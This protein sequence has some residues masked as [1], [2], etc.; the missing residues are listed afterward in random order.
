MAVCLTNLA[1]VDLRRGRVLSAQQRF[2]VAFP[3]QQELGDI[4]GQMVVL[5]GQATLC[6]QSHD[7]SAAR[8]LHSEV[9]RLARD[10]NLRQRLVPALVNLSGLEQQDR[11]F[12]EAEAHLSEAQ[13]VVD[14]MREELG[15]AEA[16]PL[17]QEYAAIIAS[18][19]VRLY[20]DS[21]RP[22]QVFEALERA[23]AGVSRLTSIA[24]NL[25][26]GCP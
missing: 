5:D 3:L 14:S 25:S 15:R 10:H 16:G 4:E 8:A 26:V 21:D 9:V 2:A 18:A 13:Q 19:R 17:V 23:R 7:F 20:L 11:R 6:V 24:M 1:K 22:T 12:T